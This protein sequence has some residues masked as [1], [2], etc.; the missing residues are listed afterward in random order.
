[1]NRKEE[2]Q[3]MGVF[4]RGSRQMSENTGK[5]SMKGVSTNR[6]VRIVC[7]FSRGEKLDESRWRSGK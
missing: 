2:T 5:P 1:M 4:P 6:A 3:G 7:S